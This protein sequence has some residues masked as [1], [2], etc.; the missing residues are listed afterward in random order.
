MVYDNKKPKNNDV[1]TLESESV[2]EDIKAQKEE[3]STET[4]SHKESWV[5]K[6]AKTSENDISR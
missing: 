6:N 4:E 5:I 2:V 3:L 1:S